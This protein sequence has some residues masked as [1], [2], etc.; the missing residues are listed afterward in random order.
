M[1]EVRLLSR[2]AWFAIAVVSALAAGPV[3][4]AGAQHSESR[5]PIPRP[6]VEA[7]VNAFNDHRLVAIG[8][9]HR[10]EQVH[11][12]IRSLLHDRRF[13]PNGGD[14]VVEFG[15][16]RYQSLIDRFTSGE[17]VPSSDLVHVWRE[18]VNILVWDAPV[19]ETFF[20]TVRAVNQ[21]RV[22]AHRL[23]V[24][25]AD[26]PID[27]SNIHDRAAWEHIVATRDRHAA[28]VIDREVLNAHRVGLLIFGSGHVEY[29]SAFGAYG[30]DGQVRLPNLAEL[31]Q[32]AHPGI[33]LFV[34]ADWMP[35]ALDARLA[36]WRPPVL[37]GLNGTWLGKAHVG[38][39]ADTPLLENL[40]DSFLYLGPTTSLTT[41]VPS[42]EIYR[43]AAYLRELIRRD[44][45]QGGANATELRRLSAM[46]L[47]GKGR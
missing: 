1:R 24:V 8:E 6:A 42:P 20:R 26:P 47:D 31:L 13:L 3:I 36:G 18:T 16:A 45:I 5:K 37:V 34:T 25:L 39:P 30:K 40:A 17:D 28:D 32:E 10:N 7:I 27:W 33:T 4:A 14:V 11:A 38:P 41:S 22:A 35:K 2:Q 46:F 15:N 44:A 21:D 12:L 9:M 29:E 43:D 19:Y 23:R